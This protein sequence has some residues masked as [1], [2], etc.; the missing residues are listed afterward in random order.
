ME[1][2]GTSKTLA[3]AI[4]N[5]LKNNIGKPVETAALQEQLFDLKGQGRFSSFSYQMTN[6][7]NKSGLLV[8]AT[9]KSYAPPIVQPL[10]LFGGSN[11]SGVD[12]SA[13]ARI[14]FLDFG[15]YRAELRNDVIIG[16]Q[17]GINSQ[18]YRPLNIASKW[19]IA[20]GRIRRLSA[21]SDLSERC[22]YRPVSQDLRGRRHSSWL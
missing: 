22:F 4:E 13:G 7:D 14:T 18:Y 10:L 21:I 1:V 15:S 20:A 17:Y 8:T 12:F 6:R 3:N 16:A 2:V 9:E 11:F 19:F 5:D